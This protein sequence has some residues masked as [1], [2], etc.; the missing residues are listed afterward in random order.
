M[1]GSIETILFEL[2]AQLKT[3]EAKA[4]LDQ[5]GTAIKGLEAGAAPEIKFKGI[6]ALKEE[7]RSLETVRDHAMDFSTAKEAQSKI[8]S[9]E[10]E[11]AA[12]ESKLK[13]VGETSG[14]TFSHL[15][16]KV[17][18]VGSSLGGLVGA[19]ALIGGAGLGAEKLFEA[20]EKRI[21]SLEDQKIALRQAGIGEEQLGAA[22]KAAGAVTDELSEK[23]A[24]NKEEVRAIQTQVAGL[25]GISGEQAK[26]V[27][28]IG[29]AFE[30]LG[31]PAKA[32]KAILAGSGSD[33]AKGA[34]QTLGEKVPSLRAALEGA[35]TAGQK[36]DAVFKGLAPTLAG[37]KDA[38]D[39]PLGTMEKVKNSLS[40]SLGTLGEQLIKIVAPLA[41]VLLP[42]VSVI[43]DTIGELV[44]SISSAIE[45]ITSLFDGVGGSAG[46]FGTVLKTLVDVSLLPVTFAIKGVGF[47]LHAV[48][49]VW[50]GAKG[51]V[52]DIGNFLGLTSDVDNANTH[53]A[54]SSREAKKAFE[55]YSKSADDLT[56]KLEETTGAEHAVASDA[57]KK[58]IEENV[59]KPTKDLLPALD[60]QNAKLTETRAAMDK[61]VASGNKDKILETKKA[62]D[63][64]SAAVKGSEEQLKKNLQVLV[65]NGIVGKG[66][67]EEIAKGMGIST[68]EAAKLVPV[69]AEINRGLEDQKKNA[70]DAAK[71]VHGIAAAFDAEVAAANKA[72]N[73]TKSAYQKAVEDRKKA[74]KE[75][76]ADAQADAEKQIADLRKSGGDQVQAVKQHNASKEEADKVFATKV[77]AVHKSAYEEDIK[78]LEVAN[79]KRETATVAFEAELQQKA[80]DAFLTHKRKSYELTKAEEKLIADR[81]FDDATT[82]EKALVDKVASIGAD[83]KIEGLSIKVD[84]KE[85]VKDLDDL[86]KRDADLKKSIQEKHLASIKLVPVVDNSAINAANKEIEGSLAEFDKWQ[87]DLDR[88][89]RDAKIAN[90]SVVDERELAALL[91]KQRRELD[92]FNDRRAS[93]VALMQS[94]VDLE[95]EILKRQDNEREALLKKQREKEIGEAKKSFDEIAGAFSDAF[96]KAVEDNKKLTGKDLADKEAGFQKEIDAARTAYSQGE[97]DY[98]TYQSKLKQISADRAAFE[99]KQNAGAGKIIVDS[100][101]NTYDAAKHAVSDFLV[102]FAEK[103]IEEAAI[104]AAVEAEKTGASAAGQAARGVIAAAETVADLAVAAG[105]G[106]AAAATA[107]FNAITAL[108]FPVDLIAAG[109]SVAAVAGLIGGLTGLIK[110][111]TGG[112]GLVGEKGP[113]I[114]GP[115]KDFSQFASQ[116]IAE[117][118]RKTEQ[119][120]K[121]ENPGTSG[122][123]GSG[124]QN[125]KIEG[126]LSGKTR[127]L[128]VALQKERMSNALEVVGS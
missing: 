112:L 18:E 1:A 106:V 17:G 20:G 48:E 31:V 122:K 61:A 67:T 74:I 127:D 100:F 77:N 71:S 6:A 111:E 96:G 29:L 82:A 35:G 16:E 33:E 85:A 79:K 37:L 3:D 108:P 66:S 75:G 86:L 110:F 2:R 87:K 42:V 13:Q 102:H 116:L 26:K 94:E 126:K 123:R 107:A 119:I 36:V 58:N 64:Q 4:S 47:A 73:E 76:D 25:G 46:G 19:G 69:V 124:T 83:G 11:V 40:E 23:Y 39:G 55:E 128:T 101:K 93:G 30:Q 62:F 38:A 63:E 12:L 41:K 44:S 8:S 49:D 10:K 88:Q 24:K 99:A 125:I 103:K 32:F 97:S 43:G 60:A 54:A 120:I 118:M 34:I 65:Q 7:L 105:K 21:K 114:I 121:N 22:Q 78:A 27:T 89:L 72:L 68:Q 28:E 9:V 15:K 52:S 117:S 51:V 113:E 59:W 5:L 50:N 109:A 53:A 84:P 80:I 104:T 81:K 92:Y 45:P 95:K 56:K 70:D 115:T 98:R 57:Y 14:G 90:I 91:E